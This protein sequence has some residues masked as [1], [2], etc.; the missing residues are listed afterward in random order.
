MVTAQHRAK[1][2][3]S[4][5]H[6]EASIA[7]DDSITVPCRG[8]PCAWQAL[9]Q[10]PPVSVAAS[11]AYPRAGVSNSIHTHTHTHT[12][13]RTHV[14]TR[15]RCLRPRTT[16]VAKARDTP[17]FWARLFVIQYARC[18]QSSFGHTLFMAIF[19][20]M[21]DVGTMTAEIRDIALE[22]VAKSARMV[23]TALVSIRISGC[24]PLRTW[25][26][27]ARRIPQGRQHRSMSAQSLASCSL[28]LCPPSLESATS[29]SQ[30]GSSNC[31]PD[32]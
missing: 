26:M 31:S 7:I 5:Q 24:S 29:Q 25:A 2:E 16:R 6:Q 18:S 23:V 32:P 13:T 19:E 9:H 11:P 10:Q 12:H 30:S 15:T 21:S 14:H 17:P 8:L 3:H 27:Q 22:S 1:Q 20:G 28:A 4:G